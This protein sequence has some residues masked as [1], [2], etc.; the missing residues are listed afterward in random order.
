[1]YVPQCDVRGHGVSQQ[2]EPGR[3]GRPHPTAAHRRRPR[4]AMRRWYILVYSLIC[5]VA[6]YT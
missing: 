3:P 5:I 6:F 2:A 4:P 1:M